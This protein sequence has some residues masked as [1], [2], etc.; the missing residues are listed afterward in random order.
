MCVETPPITSR[1]LFGLTNKW[2]VLIHMVSDIEYSQLQS[3]MIW[4]H[5]RNC[6][7]LNW[8][9]SN[10]LGNMSRSPDKWW[11]DDI[12]SVWPIY[13]LRWPASSSS[14]GASNHFS[15]CASGFSSCRFLLVMCG[16][17][18]DSNSWENSSTQL[19]ETPFLI[20]HRTYIL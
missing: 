19:K 15:H 17:R 3:R 8:K 9:Q 5:H 12:T 11:P 14:Y 6:V 18:N 10:T 20:V 16:C 2:F 4:S 1:P 13:Y 7:R